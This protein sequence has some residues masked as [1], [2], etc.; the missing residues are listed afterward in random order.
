MQMPHPCGCFH[1]QLHVIVLCCQME[2]VL[3]VGGNCR[4]GSID[5]VGHVGMYEG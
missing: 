2:I 5:S 4:V 1:E 3:H